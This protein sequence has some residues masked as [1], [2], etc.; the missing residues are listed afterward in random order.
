MPVVVTDHVDRS[1]DKSL[2]RGKVGRIHSWVP[3][4]EECSKFEDGARILKH[5]PAVVFVKFVK[6]NG[7]DV[8][9]TLDGLKEP[10]L[11][12]I[13]P[14][15]GCFY[16]DKGRMHPVLQIR[17]Q[18]LPLA[19]AFAMTSHAAQGQTF[20]RGVV[21]D[22]CLSKGSNIMSSYVSMTRVQDRQSLLIYRPF[23][24]KLF[25]RGIAEGPSILLQLLR[26]EDVNWKALE[27]RY[28]PKAVCTGCRTSL[29]KKDYALQQWNSKE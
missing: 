9:W 2:L 29:F 23:P 28:A 17:R 18:Q 1:V 4:H 3:H 21:V 14:R 5:L 16:L 10:G 19:P 25:D 20:T 8:P 22:L 6:K 13:V 24:R 15:K 12:P 26:G 27:A 11:Y 7:K